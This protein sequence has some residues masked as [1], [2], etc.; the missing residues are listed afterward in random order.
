V[1]TVDPYFNAPAS[2]SN[3]GGGAAV[4]AGNVCTFP[5]TVDYPFIGQVIAGLAIG[6]VLQVGVFV[7]A[8][9]T[10]QNLWFRVGAGGNVGVPL[11]L[12]WNWFSYEVTT[13]AA[14]SVFYDVPAGMANADGKAD[15]FFVVKV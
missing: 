3:T 13:V 14:V 10:N 5:T 6:D 1:Q 11:A 8:M 4:I 9:A 15:F 12:G 7:R 2:W